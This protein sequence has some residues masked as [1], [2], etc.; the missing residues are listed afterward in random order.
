MCAKLAR[1]PASSRTVSWRGGRAAGRVR[2]AGRGSPTAAAGPPAAATPSNP[3]ARAC[4]CGAKK[5]CWRTPIPRTRGLLGFKSGEVSVQAGSKLC[6]AV[7][8][9]RQRRR[10]ARPGGG[11]GRAAGAGARGRGAEA[12]L[13]VAVGA[14]AAA[15][16]VRVAP[17]RHGCRRSAAARPPPDLPLPPLVGR[18]GGCT[19]LP[20]CTG[21]LVQRARVSAWIAGKRRTGGRAPQSRPPPN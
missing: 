19:P 14:G 18:A 17:P 15:A 8:L 13:V 9:L 1:A 21:R 5:P 10:H 6:C 20:L 12:V 16:A 7:L 3:R 11:R 2:R 4:W